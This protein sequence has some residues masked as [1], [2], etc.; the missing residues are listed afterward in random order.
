MCVICGALYMKRFVY[1]L[2]RIWLH[3]YS[4]LKS[5][6]LCDMGTCLANPSFQVV[7]D[8]VTFGITV[9]N[10]SANM[11]QGQIPH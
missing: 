6:R 10:I 7:Y 5:V 3:I 9:W 4:L 2:N 11:H 1:D 8:C